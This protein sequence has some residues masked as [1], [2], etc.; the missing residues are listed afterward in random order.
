[1]EATAAR[2]TVLNDGGGTKLLLILLLD[3]DRAAAEEEK[4]RMEKRLGRKSGIDI[5]A[6]IHSARPSI[7]VLSPLFFSREIRA[8][9]KK[10]EY[11]SPLTSPTITLPP[12]AA[13][14]KKHTHCAC[15]MMCVVECA[16][17][18]SFLRVHSPES[19]SVGVNSTRRVEV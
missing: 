15:V 19:G 18:R 1:M 11:C 2:Q 17:A 14:Q 10:E 16:R 4:K 9:G 12:V 5:S 8:V 7:T 3:G 13:H 6:R